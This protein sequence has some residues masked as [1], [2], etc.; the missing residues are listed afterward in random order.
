MGQ[1]DPIKIFYVYTCHSSSLNQVTYKRYELLDAV[2]LIP[3]YDCSLN[4]FLLM[5]Q[6]L[7]SSLATRIVTMSASV[8]LQ[9]RQRFFSQTHFKRYSNDGLSINSCALM[10]HDSKW[11]GLRSSPSQRSN[12]RICYSN[13]NATSG[14]I[15]DK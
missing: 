13:D 14:I 9:N 5:L 8:E 4:L 1:E 11:A 10:S 12:V 15:H 7:S 2:L 6:L 3:L